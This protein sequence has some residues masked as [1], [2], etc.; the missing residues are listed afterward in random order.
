[1]ERLSGEVVEGE[2][3]EKEDDRW[4]N[5]DERAGERGRQ[6]VKKMGQGEGLRTEEEVT[7]REILH[8]RERKRKMV[9]SSLR[10]DG[11]R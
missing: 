10:H 3:R 11:R 4:G 6:N 9:G 5:I 7:R 8:F 2:K 1:M